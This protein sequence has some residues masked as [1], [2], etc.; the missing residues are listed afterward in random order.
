MTNIKIKLIILLIVLILAFLTVPTYAENSKIIN[1]STYG[2]KNVTTSPITVTNTTKVYTITPNTKPCSKQVLR[3]TTYNKYTKNYYTLITYMQ[4]FE[5]YGGGTL[6]LKKGTYT[7]SNT[8]PIPSNVN[9][10][11]EDGV[12]INKGT[13]T[14][15]KKFTA[16]ESIFK[17]VPPSK[18]K[19][20][21]VYSKYNGV[22]N[23]NIIGKGTAVINLRYV[24]NTIALVCGHNKNIQLQGITFLNVNCGHFIE[25]DATNGMKISNCKFMG[26][27]PSSKLD[28]EAI[29]LD[30]PDR[31]TQGFHAVWS[32][33]DKTPDYNIIIENN[34]FKGLDRAIGTHKYSQVKTNG[35]YIVNKGQKYHT[36]IIIRNN[37]I[38]NTRC[39]AIRILNWKDSQIT[40][41]YIADVTKNSHNYRAICASGA[42]NLT[43]KYNYLKS[44]NRPIEILP[45]KN[46]G[47]GWIYSITYNNITHANIADMKYNYC[48]CVADNFARI[49]YKYKDYRNTRKIYLLT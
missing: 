25:L 28:A 36:K 44:M 15:T 45:T 46:T 11:L 43:I 13:V 21:G 8:V 1:N 2:L 30:T 33:Y 27:K 38:T 14:G 5:K 7:I 48:V 22:K 32:T 24:K 18:L 4:K 16:S 29:N 17:L 40:N 3:Y 6:I 31:N 19:K 20:S 26:S 47:T 41:N 10:I 49:T 35:K 12:T 37:I 23:V 42:V 9:L 34:I 39:D